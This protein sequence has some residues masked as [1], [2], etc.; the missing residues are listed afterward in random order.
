LWGDSFTGGQ[1]IVIG[2][3]DQRVKAIVAQVPVFG[4]KPPEVDPDQ[5]TFDIITEVI[6]RGDVRGSPETTVGPMPVVSSD[7]AGTPSLLGSPV[8]VVGL[9]AADGASRE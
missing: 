6:S 9:N 5:A 1:V 3:M 7:Q 4:A 2:A 8:A